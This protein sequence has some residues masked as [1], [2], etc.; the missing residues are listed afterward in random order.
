MKRG[1]K[2][3]ALWDS[4]RSFNKSKV[5][6][7]KTQALE[8]N[9]VAQVTSV[10]TKEKKQGRPIP[11]KTAALLKAVR[12]SGSVRMQLCRLL[13]DFTSV[14]TCRIPVQSSWH[15][16]SR[17][18]LLKLFKSKLVTVD[19]IVMFVTCLEKATTSREEAWIWVIVRRLHRV[20][21][22][23]QVNCLVTWQECTPSGN[24]RELTLAYRLLVTKVNLLCEAN[25]L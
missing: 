4:G 21:P 23:E 18:I 8:T 2:M 7:L 19:G 20:V 17:L 6:K 16:Q 3:R 12:L 11:L 1:S 9:P 14:D 10:G 22:L 24:P 15:I 13:N 5:E 25:T